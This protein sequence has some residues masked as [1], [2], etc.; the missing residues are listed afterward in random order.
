M[1]SV[2]DLPGRGRNHSIEEE[3]D[4]AFQSL[5]TA[6]D[7]FI[8]QRANRKDYGTDC[9]IEVLDEGR[10]SNVRIDVQLKG[11]ERALNSDGSLSISVHR[12][13][14]NYL[15]VRPYSQFVAFHIPTKTLRVAS[16]E[17]VLRQYEHKNTNW[18]EQDTLTVQFSEL[19]SL[20]R[21]KVLA[22]LA[23]SDGR[24]SRDRRIAQATAANDDLL[25]LLREG[26]RMIHVPDD[27]SVAASKLQGLYESGK[28]AEISNAFDQFAAILGKASDAMGY[29][30]MA[31]INLGMAKR[32]RVPERIDA[33]IAH[34]EQQIGGGRY[35]VGSLR[36]TIGNAF[37]ALGDEESAKESYQA[38]IADMGFM[39][40]SEAASQCLKNLGSSYERLGNEEMAAELYHS[41]LEKNPHLSEAH[42]ALGLF[43]QRKG[44]F[45]EALAHYDAVVF[46][47]R[48]L[49]GTTPVIG[50]RLNALFN[51]GQAREA[52]RS[53]NQLLADADR[54]PWIWSWCARQVAAFGRCSVEAAYAAIAFWE[55]YVREHPNAS[56]A[57]V[58]LLLTQFYLRQKADD[59]GK[60]YATCRTEFDD[61]I[62]HVDPEQT[63]FIWDR[64]G[65][66]AQ[67]EQNWVEAECCFRK[68]YEI[69]GGQYGYCLG[70]ALNFLE[71]YE[72]ALPL[73]WAQAESTHSDAMSWFQVAFARERL[74][75]VAD[76]VDAYRKALVLDP[77]HSLAMFNMAGVLWNNGD[78]DRA[79]IIFRTA[80]QQ[81]PDHE[82]TEKLRREFP[83]LF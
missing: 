5:I 76:A 23:R 36:Y 80:A 34:F 18:S 46:T 66:W 11:S 13:N 12:T 27:Q 9:Q 64:L 52:F 31:E 33:G 32:S 79:A 16:T 48:E 39:A 30:Y 37:S 17:S 82:L 72:E 77:D 69:D 21:L 68:A 75:R 70:V 38:A 83:E 49:G 35:L 58:E 7:H 25:P 67:D 15:V 42:F 4:A 41:A 51:L 22:D 44:D 20:D 6:S 60:D 40:D 14:L 45:E 1:G 78:H 24:A 55:K 2:N 8:L 19:L 81:F 10:A 47:E 61:I 65:H 73:V 59:I 56:T 29:C 53:I 26:Q 62:A 57:R 74:G 71:R 54:E 28:D 63:A 3:A 43:S 50:W